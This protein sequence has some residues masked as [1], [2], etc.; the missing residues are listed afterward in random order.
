MSGPKV[1]RSLRRVEYD[2]QIAAAE[3]NDILA[4]VDIHAVSGYDGTTETDNTFTLTAIAARIEHPRNVVVTMEAVNLT[5]GYV[6]VYGMGMQGFP[7][8]ELFTLTGSATLTGNVPFLTVDRV[9]VWGCTGSPGETD[10]ISIG[11]GAKI[12]V[13]L[14]SHEKLVDVVKER[15]DHVDIAVTGTVNRQYG[16]YIPASTLDAAKVLELWYTTDL[17]ITW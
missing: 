11:I 1:I 6:K 2:S 9:S 15:F 13:P 10:H 3:T 12:G 4:Q 5:G 14:S 16:T 17:T 7:V 8:N